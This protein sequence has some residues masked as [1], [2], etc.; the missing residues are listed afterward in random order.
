M[1]ASLWLA[2]CAA[3]VFLLAFLACFRPIRKL[4]FCGLRLILAG[5]SL[6]ACNAAGL[7]IGINLFNLL[8]VAVLGIPGLCTLCAIYA[9]V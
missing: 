4:L 9:L 7:S 6:V 2:S 5:L 8:L 1:S 3:G